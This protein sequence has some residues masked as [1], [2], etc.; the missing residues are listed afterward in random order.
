MT[1]EA[2]SVGSIRGLHFRYLIA[3][4]TYSFLS[5]FESSI[6]HIL[7]AAGY[8]PESWQYGISVMLEKRAQIDLVTGIKTIVLTEEDFNFDNETGHQTFECTEMNGLIANEQH[9]IRK[10]KRAIENTIHK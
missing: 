5:E 3:C 6:S 8:T 1:N 9:Y 10:G 7:Y 2:I 4:A